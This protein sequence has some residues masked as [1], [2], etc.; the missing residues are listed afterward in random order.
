MTPRRSLALTSLHALLIALAVGAAAVATVTIA[1]ADSVTLSPAKDN[2]L[3]EDAAGSLSNGV[4]QFFFAGRT[5][6]AT[7]SIRRA[8]VAFDVSSIPAG[9]TIT[10]AQL[11]A[12][13]AQG[14]ATPRAATLHRLAAGWG[15]GASNAG[16]PGGGGAPSA[17]NDATWIH[18]FFSS[19]FW[20]S[21]GGDFA[22]GASATQS[23]ANVGFYAWGSTAA[24]VADVQQ[25]LDAPATNFGWILRGVES[26][27]GSARRLESREN[28]APSL[29]PALTVEYTP[30]PTAVDDA[31]WGNVKALYR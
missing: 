17:A 1:R 3:Y 22:A 21:P 18:T 31:S 28:I 25:W 2:T 29:R 27:S 6:Q 14:D 19:A 11:V 30:P 7:G 9:S 4:G 12:H 26:A 8:L 5:A 13:V 16:T 24:M 20:T 23:L 15:E 10:G